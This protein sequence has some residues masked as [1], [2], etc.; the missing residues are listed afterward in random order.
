[1]LEIRIDLATLEHPM[2]EKRESVMDPAKKLNI[3]AD[4]PRY[5]GL[6]KEDN[7]KGKDK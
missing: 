2:K 4:F 7:M 5:G 3:P 1:M 6:T